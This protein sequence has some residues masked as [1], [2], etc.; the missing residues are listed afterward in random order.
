MMKSFTPMGMRRYFLNAH[1]MVPSMTMAYPA[2][3]RHMPKKRKKKGARRG[4]GSMP[5]YFGGE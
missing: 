4:V 1:Q 5:R 3:P 2:S